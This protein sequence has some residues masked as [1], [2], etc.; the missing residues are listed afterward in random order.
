[1]PGHAESKNELILNNSSQISK[2]RD[3][4][5]EASW[6]SFSEARQVYFFIELNDPTHPN[7]S[8]RYEM[9][10]I[11]DNTIYPH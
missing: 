2:T 9:F 6:D 8:A 4:S 10:T 1:M 3:D 5:V 7:V 11:S